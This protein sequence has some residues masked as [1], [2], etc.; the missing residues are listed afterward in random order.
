M[1]EPVNFR[2]T[3]GRGVEA[4]VGGSHLRVGRDTWLR[5]NGVAIDA[6]T[7]EQRREQ[8]SFS[9][10]CVARESRFI[11]WIGLDDK[12][13]EEAAGC[14]AELRRLGARRLAI[15]TG[16]RAAAAEHAAQT[17]GC[18]E[19]Q[20]QLL[21]EGKVDFVKSVKAAGFRVAVVGDGINDAPALATGDVGIAMGAAGSQAAIHSAAVTLMNNNLKRVPFLVRLARRTRS[22]VWQNIGLGMLL[23]LGGL[24]LAGAGRLGPVAA[25]ILHNAGSLFIV[26]NSARLV[27]EPEQE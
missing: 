5:E 17:I 19:V 1:L 25:A 20:A 22:V 8:A 14:F 26:F 7:E 13:R 6:W 11:G 24:A 21:P 27:R 2:E 18:R 4:D 3:A 9:I 23:M 15:V 12:V 16:D 10:I